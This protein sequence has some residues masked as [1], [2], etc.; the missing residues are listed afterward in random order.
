MRCFPGLPSNGSLKPRAYWIVPFFSL[1][2]LRL[3][4]PGTP[5][6]WRLLYR[7]LH[8]LRWSPWSWHLTICPRNETRINFKM[9]FTADGR[10]ESNSSS[11]G[12]HRW[13]GSDQIIW[14]SLN[15][16]PCLLGSGRHYELFNSLCLVLFNSFQHEAVLNLILSQLIRSGA[17]RHLRSHSLLPMCISR[18]T[19]DH[20]FIDYKPPTFLTCGK[21][22]EIHH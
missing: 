1:F 15:L 5:S 11:S 13:E 17:L 8:W 6:W 7:C 10:Y 3:F 16:N 4:G 18:P 21:S 19:V 14:S 22:H 9:D 20:F 12:K 2:S